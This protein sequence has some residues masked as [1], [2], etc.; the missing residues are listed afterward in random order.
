LD[1][2]D[3]LA[4]RAGDKEDRYLQTITKAR[5]AAEREGDQKTVEQLDRIYDEITD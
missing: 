1:N 3:Q 5:N 4:E 2:E